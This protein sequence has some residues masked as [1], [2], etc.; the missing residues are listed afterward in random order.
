MVTGNFN[1]HR[2]AL[3]YVAEYNCQ[4]IAK[5]RNLRSESILVKY[6]CQGG[7]FEGGRWLILSWLHNQPCLK[8]V[9]MFYHLKIRCCVNT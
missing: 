1:S 4:M 7:Y 5:K 8:Q 3:K 9:V 2:L 6:P